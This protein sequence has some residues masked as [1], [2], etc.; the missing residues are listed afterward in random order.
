METKVIT[1][2]SKEFGTV[3]KIKENGVTL[4]CGADVAKAL[5]YA[6]PRKAIIDHCK[7]VLKRNTLTNGGKQT[8]NFIPEGDVWRLICHSKLPNAEQ[9][10]KWIFDDVV[11]TVVKTGKYEIPTKGEQ[12]TLETS[13]YH[14]FDK[15]YNGEPVI[16]LA[17]FEHFTGVS[18]DCALHIL[19]KY[20]TPALDY[21]KLSGAEL[22]DFKRENPQYNRG[23]SCV[24]VVTKSGFISLMKF[25]GC[26]TDT[27]KC[28]IV[29]K[30]TTTP[31][32]EKSLRALAMDVHREGTY[33][34]ANKV[35]EILAE[36]GERV[37]G[38]IGLPLTC[39]ADKISK[40]AVKFVISAVEDHSAKGLIADVLACVYM[41]NGTRDV[42]KH[43]VLTRKGVEE[44]V[45][46]HNA[47]A[48][49][50]R[51][52]ERAPEALPST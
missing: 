12:L 5:G 51:T 10:E 38:E 8:L 31:P 28:F 3:R 1:M 30:K 22:L 6:V 7:G 18:S 45:Q 43:R 46:V 50:K 47:F 27:P 15:T 26:N 52:V 32:T 29:E 20:C 19:K 21:H 37:N 11:P 34:G 33:I 16:T 25:Y 13:E 24:T 14:Y 44:V 2:A 39:A 41:P 42:Y 48:V 9:F 40:A 35:E 49:G 17:D 4:Y 36:Y 23:V